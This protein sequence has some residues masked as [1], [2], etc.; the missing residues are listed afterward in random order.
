[1]NP[2]LS[3]MILVANGLAEIDQEFYFVGGAAVSL[4]A[5]KKFSNTE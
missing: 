1:M 4:Y 3:N 2:S 5:D